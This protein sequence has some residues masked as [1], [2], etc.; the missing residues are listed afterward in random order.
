MFWTSKDSMKGKYRVFGDYKQRQK[1]SFMYLECK[2]RQVEYDSYIF[3]IK[4]KK[5]HI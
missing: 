4:P 2:L 3:K 1:V 5:K